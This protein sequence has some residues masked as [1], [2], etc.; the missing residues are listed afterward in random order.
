[1]STCINEQLLFS[2]RHG[3]LLANMREGGRAELTVIALFW[4]EGHECLGHCGVRMKRGLETERRGLKET[5]KFQ[6]QFR[7]KHSVS[8]P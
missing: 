5:K 3:P 1:M 4:E 8:I 6:L 2:P 7:E